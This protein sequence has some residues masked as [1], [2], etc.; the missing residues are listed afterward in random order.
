MASI[1]LQHPPLP[2]DHCTAITVRP[3]SLRR[4]T[5]SVVVVLGAQPCAV[6]PVL[7]NLAS[8]SKPP[9]CPLQPCRHR[10]VPITQAVQPE[11]HTNKARPGLQ[12]RKQKEE[13]ERK[14]TFYNYIIFVFGAEA[15]FDCG[16][17]GI[18]AGFG[19][20]QLKLS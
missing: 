15:L 18:R 12:N 20:W 16:L 1:A 3:K 5:H 2:S 13:K 7:F 14:P 11:I 8:I 4:T 17:A 19:I 6:E 9:P 10:Q